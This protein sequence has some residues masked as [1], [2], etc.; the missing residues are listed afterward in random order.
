MSARYTFFKKT[1][2]QGWVMLEPQ[3]MRLKASD[4]STVADSVSMGLGLPVLVVH[5]RRGGLGINVYE[6]SGGVK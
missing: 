5:E 2:D 6:S 4:V 1:P 3:F